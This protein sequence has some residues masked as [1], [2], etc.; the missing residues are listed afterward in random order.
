MDTRG[1]VVK[2]R[3]AWPHTGVR[4]T[5]VTRSFKMDRPRREPANARDFARLLVGASSDS[6]DFSGKY[7]RHG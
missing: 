4:I 7:L 6:G 3:L 5:S 1:L 2:I